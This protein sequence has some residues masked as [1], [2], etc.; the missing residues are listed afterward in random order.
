M[1]NDI[2]GKMKFIDFEDDAEISAYAGYI[3]WR[4]LHDLHAVLNEQAPGDFSWEICHMLMKSLCELR[5]AATQVV[6]ITMEDMI[7]QWEMEFNFNNPVV[8]FIPIENDIGIVDGQLQGIDIYGE[9][10]GPTVVRYFLFKVQQAYF[11]RLKRD[12]EVNDWDGFIVRL[13]LQNDMAEWNIV[14]DAFRDALSRLDYRPA[15]R[16]NKFIAEYMNEYKETISK[17]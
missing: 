14:V 7:L 4:V 12:G 13:L 6:Q 5:E 1:T 11:V 2:F 15:W 9:D 10:K 3:C 8:N 16:D 17:T